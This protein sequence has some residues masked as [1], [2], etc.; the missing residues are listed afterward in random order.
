MYGGDYV[1]VEVV[2]VVLIEC[3]WLV[4]CDMFGGVVE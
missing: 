2:V 1:G 3:F 4:G